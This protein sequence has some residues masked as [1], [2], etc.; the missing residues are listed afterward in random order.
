MYSEKKTENTNIGEP[1]RVLSLFN[2]HKKQVYITIVVSALSIV[3]LSSLIIFKFIGK[4]SSLKD[5]FKGGKKS[6]V[7]KISTPAKAY[8]PGRYVLEGIINDEAPVAI[9]NG[10]VFKEGDKIDKFEV[11]SI[12]A[13]GVQLL[14]RQSNTKIDL[15]F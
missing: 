5:A 10:E 15:A 4:L 12:T 14:D 8:F 11:I 9:I 2:K 6:S 1:D 13:Q 3:C 7:S